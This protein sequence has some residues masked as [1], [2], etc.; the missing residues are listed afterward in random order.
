[1]KFANQKLISMWCPPRNAA[2]PAV[3]AVG[4]GAFLT[5][6]CAQP[7]LPLMREVFGVSEIRISWIMGVTTMAIALSAPFAGMIAETFNRKTLIIFS[8][9]AIAT[10]T[11]LTATA[12]DLELILVWRFIQGVF[13]SAVITSTTALIHE[14]FQKSIEQTM[15]GYVFGTIC[16]GGLG[17]FLGGL[18]SSYW[19]WHMVFLLVG[20]LQLLTVFVVREWLPAISDSPRRTWFKAWGE[21]G[22][23]LTN[24]R[25]LANCSMGFTILFLLC[26]V[27]TYIN[28]RLSGTPFHLSPAAL[29]YV[30]LAYVPGGCAIPFA[31]WYFERFG[32][33]STAFFAVAMITIGLLLT[34]NSSLWMVLPGLLVFSS[35]IFIAQTAAMI[36]VG[37][38]VDRARSIA[39]AMYVASYY[40][41]GTIGAILPGWFWLKMGWP[42]C[43]GLFIAAALAMFGAAILADKASGVFHCSPRLGRIVG[44]QLQRSE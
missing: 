17:R 9:F 2:I 31:G 38:V 18:V 22:A 11:L 39:S 37:R 41:G 26:G 28:F 36:A 5:T 10:A 33:R 6:Y 21:F 4:I 1:M 14:Q 24:R 3:I 23:H 40:V 19:D 30:S 32:F 44:S 8:L 35:G 12:Y 16:G 25:L 42:A 43:I 15:A 34:L 27:F 7:V 29:G 13:V 20:G